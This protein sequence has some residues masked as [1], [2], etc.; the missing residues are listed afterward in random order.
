MHI[1][2]H[3]TMEVNRK[4]YIL[5][6]SFPDC[7]QGLRL[8]LYIGLHALPTRLVQKGVAGAPGNCALWVKLAKMFDV[9]GLIG[10]TSSVSRRTAPGLVIRI[11][12]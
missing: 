8:A 10:T 2:I 11:T 12:R 9:P 7:A 1:R 5:R 3:I 6:V 4:L